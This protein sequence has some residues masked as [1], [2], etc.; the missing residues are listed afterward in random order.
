MTCSEAYTVQPS[1]S[2]PRHAHNKLSCFQGIASADTTYTSSHSKSTSTASAS[3]SHEREISSAWCDQVHLIPYN[4]SLFNITRE[5]R[6]NEGLENADSA[7]ESEN[8]D[9]DD[10]DD[11]ERGGEGE[12]VDSDEQESKK[13][14]RNKPTLSC[15]ECVGKKM[16]VSSYLDF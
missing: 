2:R 13:R 12:F 7:D 6:E 3:L 1:S 11:D 4:S 16:R 14:K 10:Y 9:D 15:S 5:E 8:D